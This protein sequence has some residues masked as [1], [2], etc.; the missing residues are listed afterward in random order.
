MEPGRKRPFFQSAF[1]TW[2]PSEFAWA[3][4]STGVKG[5]PRIQSREGNG[6]PLQY[7]CLENPMDGE[8]WW[9]AVHGFA[10]LDTTERLHFH[11]LE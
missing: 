9:T 7:S 1:A 11:A 8:V 2:Q 5:F 10:E 4:V 6:T 3:V